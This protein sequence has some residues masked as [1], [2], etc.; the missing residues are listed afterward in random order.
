MR[1]VVMNILFNIQTVYIVFRILENNM[2]NRKQPN[3]KRCVS[4]V[5]G[6]ESHT[7]NDHS[8]IHSVKWDD[9]ISDINTYINITIE[10]NKNIDD[11]NLEK[12]I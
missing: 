2:F 11:Y 9:F 10:I 6:L 8:Y 12:V 7:G 4:D 5:C 1:I 3:K